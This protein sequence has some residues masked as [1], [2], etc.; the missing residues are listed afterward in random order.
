M[1][2]LAEGVVDCG[3]GLDEGG[4]VS[5]AFQGGKEGGTVARGEVEFMGRGREEVGAYYAG[6]FG[7]E[8]LCR[9]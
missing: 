9:D 3:A 6:D 4:G 7:A 2:L 8:G 5:G 1:G